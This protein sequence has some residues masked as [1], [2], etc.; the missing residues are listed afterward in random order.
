MVRV[1]VAIAA[2]L[3]AACGGSST[4]APP[5]GTHLGTS[6]VEDPPGFQYS[7]TQLEEACVAGLTPPP[8]ACPAGTTATLQ[9]CG[10]V[11][12][13]TVSCPPPVYAPGDVC[14]DVE[15]YGQWACPEA[16]TAE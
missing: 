13:G 9:V 16:T 7:Q 10:A 4:I 15:C 6:S 8:G 14:R 2:L 12:G 5:C 3:L 11:L 1:L